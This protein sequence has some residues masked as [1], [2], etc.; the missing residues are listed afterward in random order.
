MNQLPYVFSAYFFSSLTS[1][2]GRFLTFHHVS[3][4]YFFDLASSRLFGSLFCLL[5]LLRRPVPETMIQ[6]QPQEDELRKI[7]REPKEITITNNEHIMS[8]QH[9]LMHSYSHRT[10][11]RSSQLRYQLSNEQK[12]ES[13]LKNQSPKPRKANP[14]NLSPSLKKQITKTKKNQSPKPIPKP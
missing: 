4:V 5:V 10:Y 12:N 3:R 14:Q 2:D 6:R 1:F 7:G 9:T 8:D 11:P 13:I